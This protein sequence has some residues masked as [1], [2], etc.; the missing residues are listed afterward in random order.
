MVQAP[1]RYWDCAA[2]D[3]DEHAEA[4]SATTSDDTTAPVGAN[5]RIGPN[6]CMKAKFPRGLSSSIAVVT[7][8]KTL[9]RSAAVNIL[10]YSITP[11]IGKSV[12]AIA[13][14]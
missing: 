9:G 14:V 10:T 2:S 8:R 11:S 6:Q 5:T 3:K 4:D 1:V 13:R 12:R 7:L